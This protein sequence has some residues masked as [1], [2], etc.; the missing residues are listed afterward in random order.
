[1]IFSA[2]DNEVKKMSSS[3]NNEVVSEAKPHTIKKFELIERYVEEWMHK[4]LNNSLCEKLIFIDCMCNSGEY[5]DVD[6]KSV[7]GTGVRVADSLYNAAFQYPTKDIHVCLN[8]IDS[9]KTEHIKCLL[10]KDTNNFHTH[11]KTMDANEYLKKIGPRLMRMRNVHTLLVYDP[12]KADIDWEAVIP[13][14]NTWGEVMLNHMVSDSIRAV[15][16]AK[17]TDTIK[18]YEKT[19][20][21]EFANLIPFGSNRRAYE[22]QIESIMA[23]MRQEKMRDFYI[24][25]FPFFNRTNSVV[26]N[27]IH[28]TTNS[29]GFSL[30]KK[31]AWQTFGG[32]SSGKNTHGNE[33]QF[34]FDLWSDGPPKTVVDEDCYYVKDI[35]EYIQSKFEGQEKVP[36]S[37]IWALLEE[38]P[39]FPSEG[40]R[41]DIKNE[42]KR[43]HGAVSV[44]RKE[45][46]FKGRS[47]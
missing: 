3:N 38:H 14:F 4:L 19:Y 43:S 31:V 5:H 20:R 17:K 9:R 13:F 15:A 46:S 39:V 27:F 29:K 10:P 42:L 32:K 11:I 26:Y 36:L 18:K 23:S 37:K 28:Y 40:F 7:I 12:Y 34:T 35:A 30:F 6:G 1:M 41:T 45:L 16:V 24:A 44:G 22:E 33:N 8:D 2:R 21:T 25:A 47:K